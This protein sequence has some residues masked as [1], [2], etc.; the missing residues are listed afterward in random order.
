MLSSI[1]QLGQYT[2][3]QIQYLGHMFL[4]LVMALFY[5]FLP[6]FRPLNL[7]KHT[8]FIGIRSLFVIVLTA[9]FTGMVLAL[10]GYYTLARFGSEGLVGPLVALSI[11]QE[12]GP[13]LSALMV[14]GRAGSA[15][16]GELGVMRI[17]EQIDAL[18]VMGIHPFKHLIAPRLEA[19]IIA[20]PLL[21]LIFDVVG[22]MGGYVVS[23]HLLGMSDGVYFGGIEDKVAIKDVATSL[24]KSVSF[25]VIVAWVCTYK[26]F[27]TERG[28]E[29]VGHAITS[30]VVL[31]S[32]IVLIW[33]Y[34]VT[35]ALL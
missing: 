26:G 10:Q 31:S 32:V 5:A 7:L 30:A 34:F 18:E 11:L 3:K 33:D 29:G 17:K 22:I 24:I 27:F 2:L 19:T 13:V 21:T 8:Y 4:F 14:T 28:A 1:R 12:L 15:M 35:A 20:L 23:V 16:A 25:G 6:P 9:A